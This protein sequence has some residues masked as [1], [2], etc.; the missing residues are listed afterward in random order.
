MEKGLTDIELEA[1]SRISRL[2]LFA[3]ISPMLGLAGTLIPLGP[4]LLGISHGDLESLAQNLVVAF[5]TTVL[6]LFAGGVF[7]AIGAIRRQVYAQDIANAEF[8]FQCLTQ[9]RESEQDPAYV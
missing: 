6:G 5:S 2:N 8:V 7:F 4:A 1:A 3:R 9:T